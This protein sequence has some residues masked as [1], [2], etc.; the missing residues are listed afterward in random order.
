MSG[1]I[2]T[3]WLQ[4][5]DACKYAGNISK[6]IMSNW[7]KKGLP[8]FRTSGKSPIIIINKKNIDNFLNQN[9]IKSDIEEITDKIIQNIWD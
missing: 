3:P 1:N 9:E 2:E 7:L 8:H 6:R 4:F 5:D